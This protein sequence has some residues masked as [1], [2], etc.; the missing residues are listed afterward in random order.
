[1]KVIELKSDPPIF[2]L[3]YRGL[4]NFDMRETR[5][6]DVE[7][8]DI[9]YLRE[10]DRGS[11][12]YSGRTIRYLVLWVMNGPAYAGLKKGSCIMSL[13]SSTIKMENDFP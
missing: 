2:D 8:G 10:F 7:A 12:I 4:K 9:L 1:M 11:Q 3:H 13:H 5:D 6:R